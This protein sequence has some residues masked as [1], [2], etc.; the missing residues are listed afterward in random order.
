MLQSK[1]L[2]SSLIK[3]YNSVLTPIPEILFNYPKDFLILIPYFIKSLFYYKTPIVYAQ[4]LLETKN[5]KF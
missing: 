2:Y 1:Y 5:E 3:N 4:L